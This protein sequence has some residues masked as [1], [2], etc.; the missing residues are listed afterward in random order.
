VRLP[1][2]YA[3][4]GKQRSLDPCSNVRVAAGVCVKPFAMTWLCEDG[5][6]M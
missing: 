5:F 3:L 6:V 2:V 4:N 1:G